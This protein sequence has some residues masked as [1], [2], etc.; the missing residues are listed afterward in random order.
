MTSKSGRMPSARP[1]VTVPYTATARLSSSG[2][3]VHEEISVDD[4]AVKRLQD[5]VRLSAQ[6][7][8]ELRERLPL[9]TEWQLDRLVDGMPVY[10]RDQLVSVHMGLV[11]LTRATLDLPNL[12]VGHIVRL[13]PRSGSSVVLFAPRAAVA[14]TTPPADGNA[15]TADGDVRTSVSVDDG[16]D[17][18]TVALL[19]RWLRNPLGEK[20]YDLSSWPLLPY[21]AGGVTLAL[22]GWLRKKILALLVAVRKRFWKSTAGDDRSAKP[23]P[24][25]IVLRVPSS[26]RRPRT[27]AGARR[28]RS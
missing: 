19:G 26:R 14:A 21:A 7:A 24:V 28:R 11:G 17:T 22:I 3:Q 16:T 27:I 5:A 15:V 8:A 12:S 23:R 6:K 10:V 4:G 1:M 9:G 18:V 13:L 25:S 2:W 20:L